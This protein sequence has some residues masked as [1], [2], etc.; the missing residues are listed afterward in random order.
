MSTS[1]AANELKPA[2]LKAARLGFRELLR[3]KRLGREFIERNADDLLAQARL[4]YSRHLALGDEIRAPVGWLI[5]CAWRRT[6]NQL[7]AESNRPY[8]APIESEDTLIDE[9]SASPE[10]EV[11]TGDRYRQLQS[12]VDRLRSDERRVVELIYFKGL[13]VRE[14]G[15]ELSWDKS[16]VSRRQHD[17]LAHL[18]QFLQVDDLDS[19]EIVV[20]G[21]AAWVSRI[22]PRPKL[23]V[24]AGSEAVVDSATRLVVK[25]AGRLA[26]WARRLFT[27]GSAE[28]GT[29]AATG[30]SF[31]PL[32]GACGA[33]L[34]C[35]IAG[36][37]G[38]VGPGID[39][40]DL[41][42]GPHH[43]VRP[44]QLHRKTPPASIPA[45]P[46]Q[47]ISRLPQSHEPTAPTE[48]AAGTA[49]GAETRNTSRATKANRQSEAAF[50]PLSQTGGDQSSGSAARVSSESPPRESASSGSAEASVPSG[51]SSGSSAA[52]AT[53]EQQFQSFK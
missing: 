19:L 11:L 43:A 44:H 21:I 28:S 40:V 32:T 46:Q 20:I 38:V 3:R 49:L 16:K 39:G 12:A 15:E 36:A 34:A 31:R 13:T 51:T 35:V 33:A 10:D 47:F 1:L 23:D 26:E 45:N 41:L 8:I 42:P 17:A 29:A 53:A 27:S 5:V 9:G 24:V 50:R 4:E 18:R 25:L 52:D 48:E 7:E 6:K 22:A 14:A 30:G 37:T 2:E